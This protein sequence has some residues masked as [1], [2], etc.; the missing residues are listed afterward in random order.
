MVH[1]SSGRHTGA[2]TRNSIYAAHSVLLV[3]YDDT[4]SQFK[5]MNSWGAAWGDDGFGYLPYDSFEV[6]WDEGWFMDLTYPDF[7]EAR[8]RYST[9]SW[10]FGHPAFGFVHHC[11]EIVGPQHLRI[12]WALAVQRVEG[13]LEVEEL[14]VRPTYRHQ[15]YGKGLRRSLEK[16]AVA[17]GCRLKIW[18]SYADVDPSNISIIDKLIAP[19][20]LT[21]KVSGYRWAP[22]FASPAGE[23]EIGQPI[24]PPTYSRPRVSSDSSLVGLQV[25]PF[26]VD[27]YP[28]PLEL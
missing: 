22:A 20:G 15:G 26:R 2:V 3:G 17:L 12:A 28:L 21:R 11:V 13:W 18:I 6:A 10:G 24:Q 4:K 27:L 16:L 5:F 8:P 23:D 7:G 25:H 19:I 9:R 14:F 1:C